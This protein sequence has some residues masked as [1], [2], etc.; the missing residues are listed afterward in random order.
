V[1]VCV[2][3]PSMLTRHY[4]LLFDLNNI[5]LLKNVPSLELCVT[6]V[7]PCLHWNP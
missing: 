1:C 6:D 3:V 2:C 5:V 7:K 4:S